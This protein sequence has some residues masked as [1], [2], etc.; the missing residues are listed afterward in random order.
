MDLDDASIELHVLSSVYESN[1]HLNRILDFDSNRRRIVV[2][3]GLVLDDLNSYLKPFGLWFPVDV[4]TSSRAT[5]GGMA[6][7]NS[8]GARSIVYGTMRDNVHAIDAVLTDG[9]TMTFGEVSDNVSHSHLSDVQ[10]DLVTKLLDL[11]RNTMLR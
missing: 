5:I 6:G 3:P 11:G 9:S 1:C 8:C 10:S 4:S 2:E 7:N